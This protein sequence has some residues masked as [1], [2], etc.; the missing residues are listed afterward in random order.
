[1][2]NYTNHIF[3]LSNDAV[4]KIQNT[5]ENNK[6]NIIDIYIAVTLRQNTSKGKKTNDK[7]SLS[8]RGM[9][10]DEKSTCFKNRHIA[11]KSKNKIILK[12]K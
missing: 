2:V 4:T 10:G 9:H 5:S 11:L 1:M 8:M 12:R 3:G 6:R 7:M